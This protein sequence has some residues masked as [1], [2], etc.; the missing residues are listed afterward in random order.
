MGVTKCSRDG[1]NDTRCDR[2]SKKYGDIC[3]DCYE[4]LL[5]IYPYIDI[6]TFMN[7]TKEED[8]IMKINKDFVNAIFPK[9]P[10]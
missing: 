9:L 1:C 7:F 4:E 6:E 5:A 2:H 3:N 8:E 10:D